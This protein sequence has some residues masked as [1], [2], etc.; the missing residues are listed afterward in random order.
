MTIDVF[1]NSSIKAYVEE[2]TKLTNDGL[3]ILIN[4]V[5]GGHYMPLLDLIIDNARSLFKITV[6]SY[7]SLTKASYCC[8]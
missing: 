3:D 4:S 8:S 2:V 6:F 5:S 7:P 1:D